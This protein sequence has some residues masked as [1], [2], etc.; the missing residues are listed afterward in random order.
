MGSSQARNRTCVS[1]TGSRFFTTEPPGKPPAFTFNCF[2]LSHGQRVTIFKK[3]HL[4]Q[5]PHL[6]V[7]S[8]FSSLLFP[9]DCLNLLFPCP[10]FVFITE[11]T[12]NWLSSYYSTA[13]AKVSVTSVHITKPNGH[14]QG[15][16]SFDLAAATIHLC[17][18]LLPEAPPTA[19]T[20]WS[21]PLFPSLLL[22]PVV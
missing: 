9:A 22:T 14:F 16:A 13:P 6:P 8:F 19:Q 5:A 7:P 12:P 10:N 11:P 18:L 3:K 21:P 1:C 2:L 15:C 20:L 4:T 17:S